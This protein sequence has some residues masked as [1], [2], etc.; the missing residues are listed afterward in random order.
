MM[1]KKYKDPWHKRLEMDLQLL[2]DFSKNSPMIEFKG[3][4]GSDVIPPNE[5]EITYKVKSIVSINED[6]SPNYGEEHKVKI[7]LPQGY[8]M[9][10]SPSCYAITQTWHPNIRSSGKFEGHICINAHVLGFWHTLDLLVEQIGEMLQYKNYHAEQIQPYP[11]DPIVAKWVKNYAEPNGIV[12]K[13][14]GISTD[15]RPLLNVS[16]EWENSRNQTN[17]INIHDIRLKSSKKKQPPSETKS[18]K[19]IKIKSKIKIS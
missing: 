14:K 16:N 12:D 5:Y 2:T 10:S 18:D 13:A 4:N 8:P 3:L 1:K 6:Q 9:L 19:G 11:E 17:K 7:V 15:N